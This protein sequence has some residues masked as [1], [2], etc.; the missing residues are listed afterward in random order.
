[1]AFQIM[2]IPHNKSIKKLWFLPSEMLE[3]LQIEMGTGCVDLYEQ[4]AANMTTLAQF[5]KTSSVHLQT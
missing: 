1:M 2:L 4:N 3:N 5:I